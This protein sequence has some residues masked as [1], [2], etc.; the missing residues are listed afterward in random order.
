MHTEPNAYLLLLVF[1]STL[2]VYNFD[3][4]FHHPDDFKAKDELLRDKWVQK[5]YNWLRFFA[6]IATPPIIYSILHLPF[7]IFYVL[8]PL[9]IIALQYTFPL[10]RIEGKWLS[11]KKVTGAKAFLIA[12][13]W[14][15]VCVML[16]YLV[17]QQSLPVYEVLMLFLARFCFIA[18]LAIYFDIRDYEFDKKVGINSLA[19]VYGIQIA[20]YTTYALLLVFMGLI[21]LNP[22]YS[23][24]TA[25]WGMLS[26]GI[27]TLLL[28]AAHKYVKSEF[29][30][31]FVTD[32]LLLFQ[33]LL[34]YILH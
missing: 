32:G 21:S 8:I 14:A 28:M 15:V 11:L 6:L 25:Y 5:N 29:Y 22:F 10:V 27:I 13:V 9:F 19:V 34:V 4:L 7:A 2:F 3:T 23:E 12:G 33:L 31:S 20:R 26:S 18:A 30:Y 16:P 24:H 17:Q 1:C